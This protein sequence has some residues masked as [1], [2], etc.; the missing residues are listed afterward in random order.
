MYYRGANAALLLYDITNAS[1]FNDVRGWLEGIN[2]NHPHTSVMIAYD[3]PTE[4]KKNC[5]PDLIIFIVGSKADLVHHRQVS[6][7]LAR[8][9]LHNWFPPPKPPET[10]S[11]SRK[12]FCLVSSSSPL[13]CPQFAPGRGHLDISVA[14]QV[15]L[16]LD[17]VVLVSALTAFRAVR[18]RFALVLKLGGWHR[19]F[20]EGRLKNGRRRGLPGGGRRLETLSKV[21]GRGARGAVDGILLADW[22]RLLR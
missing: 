20:D 2:D 7:D 22:R 19:C 14:E 5:P 18:H 4:L 9:S 3:S 8:L 10:D 13:P 17:V 11:I 1:T 21:V 16:V 6:S 12:R 15:V